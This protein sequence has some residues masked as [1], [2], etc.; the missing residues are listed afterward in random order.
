M[1]DGFMEIVQRILDPG[2]GAATL[3]ILV[4]LAA[5]VVAGMSIYA[6]ML[7]LKLLTGKRCR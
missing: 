6:T 5:L 1:T 2:T 7:A 3:F 4:A